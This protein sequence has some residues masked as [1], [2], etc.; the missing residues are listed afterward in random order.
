MPE[1]YPQMRTSCEAFAH[2]QGGRHPGL[3][4]D[5]Y[6][7][8]QDNNYRAMEGKEQQDHLRCIVRAM[9][10]QDFRNDAEPLLGLWDDTVPEQSIKWEMLTV[11]RL[12]AH[13]SRPTAMENAA[14][15]LHPVYGFPYLP[16]T[17]LKGL[18]RAYAELYGKPAAERKRVFG[19]TSDGG[20][21]IFFDAWPACWPAI[22]VDIVNSH[23]KD[24]YGNPANPPAPGDWESPNPVYFLAV[25]PGQAF[26]FAVA[27]RRP[28]DGDEDVAN[29]KVWLEEGLCELG[30]GAKTAAGYGYFR[31]GGKP[32]AVQAVEE[33]ALN[34]FASWL[35][36]FLAQKPDAGRKGE[37]TD[38]IKQLPESDRAKAAKLALDRVPANLLDHKSKKSKQLGKLTLR[39]TL[40]SYV[41]EG[42]S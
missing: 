2:F 6:V 17:G 20:A 22:A 37:V 8:Y 38:R 25:E 24:Y 34:C 23:H 15:C 36:G 42:G 19:T 9:K 27:K 11:W 33:S 1:F 41:H 26:R 5:T 14:L 35:D 32:G 7:P 39:Q 29:A 31:K 30:F 3:L 18:A 21:V 13:L 28:G 40:E 10:M 16:A 12:A 4:V